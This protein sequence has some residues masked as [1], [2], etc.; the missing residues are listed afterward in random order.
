ML[1]FSGPDAGRFLQSQLATDLAAVA[2]GQWRWAALLSLKGRVLAHAP[3]AHLEE[4]HWLWWLPEDLLQ[5]VAEHL[6]RYKLRSKLQIGP[7]TVEVEALPNIGAPAAADGT[8]TTELAG[9]YRLHGVA[10]GWDLRW[11][12]DVESDASELGCD[13][14]V[15]DAPAT[16]AL[17]PWQL[18]RVRAKLAWIS[19]ASSDRHL[20]QPL[21]LLELGSVSVRKGCYPGQEIVAR[22]HYLG[23]SKRVSCLLE[24][25]QP[26]PDC[27]ASVLQGDRIVGEIV[28]A[29]PDGERYVGLAV[30]EESALG[31]GELTVE[32]RAVV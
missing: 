5:S 28:E 20:P 13:V 32:G 2:P 25:E 7:L 23:R 1:Q 9:S 18:A 22:T 3:L 17:Q 15:I 27:A 24:G 6:R 29:L 30:V 10:S 14:Q 8:A 11:V 31:E 4:E 19:A 26:V 21:G 16:A 12:V